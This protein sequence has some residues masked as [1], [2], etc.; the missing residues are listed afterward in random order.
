MEKKELKIENR[1]A[2]TH[3]SEHKNVPVLLLIFALALIVRSLNGYWIGTHLDNAV[4]FPSGIYNA[5]DSLARDILDGSVSAFWIDDISR[6]SAS[7]YPPGYSLWL[8]LIYGFSGIRSANVVQIVQIFLDSAS[9]LLIVAIG[10]NAFTRRVG[11]AAGLLAALSP[12]LAIYGATPLADAPTSWIVLIGVWMLVRAAKTQNMWWPLGAGMM[13]GASCWFRPNGMFLAAF[14]AA[15][16]FLYVSAGWKRKFLLAAPVI[17]GA[18]ILIAP[19]TVR[20]SLAFQVFMPTGMG[21]GTNL[22]EGIGETSRAAEFGAIYGDDALLEQE[23]IELNLPQDKKVNNYWPDG[24]KR[25]RERMLKA[26]N[27]IGSHPVWY[28]GVMARRMMGHLKFTGSGSPIYGSSGIHITSESCLPTSWQYFPLTAFVTVLDWIQTAMRF[29][30]LPLML[31]GIALGFRKN[32][33][34]TLV[35]MV[36]VFYYLIVG[37]FMHSEIRYSLPMQAVLFVFAGIAVVWIIERMRHFTHAQRGR[38]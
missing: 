30:L 37:T 35:I 4:I 38:K 24:V 11:V 31:V 27:V 33:R 9:V 26:L 18:L 23:R 34:I 20:N 17:L 28:A 14:W 1:Q 19:L 13:I 32:A 6:T 5:F 36:T 2:E 7:V 21:A 10:E 25:D 22:W 12:L 3:S 16:L 15:A 29:Y 8:T